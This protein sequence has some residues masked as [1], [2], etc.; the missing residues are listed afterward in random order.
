MANRPGAITLCRTLAILH[1]MLPASN[2]R[3]VELGDVVA[4]F[5][6]P[7][8]LD[9]CEEYT[10]KEFMGLQA[11]LGA[12]SVS[13]LNATAVTVNGPVKVNVIVQAGN[14]RTTG[15]LSSHGVNWI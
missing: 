11:T 14:N 1:T 4:S 15:V 5:I 2:L 13:V 8:V 12:A 7:S 3:Q 10:G 9:S 6:N